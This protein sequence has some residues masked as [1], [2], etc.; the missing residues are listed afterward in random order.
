MNGKQRCPD[1]L[2]LLTLFAGGGQ[3]LW[4]IHQLLLANPSI[5]DAV[6]QKLEVLPPECRDLWKDVLRG[7]ER[8]RRGR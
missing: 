7:M 4:D 2:I 5:L 3:D 6:D 1:D 8:N